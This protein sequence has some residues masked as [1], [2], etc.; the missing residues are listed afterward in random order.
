MDFLVVCTAS[1]FIALLTFFSGF[2]LGTL[3]LP[4][5]AVFFPVDLAVAATAVVHLYSTSLYFGGEIL[6]GLPNVDT[7]S[8]LDTSVSTMPPGM[9]SRTR[10]ASTCWLESRAR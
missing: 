4:V 5:L 2:G 1:L 9:M 7:S 6:D 10:P 8:F 3:L